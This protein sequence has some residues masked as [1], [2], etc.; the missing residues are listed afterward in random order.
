MDKMENLNAFRGGST[1]DTMQNLRPV[2][3]HIEMEQ[4]GLRESLSRD[5]NAHNML[6]QQTEY[7]NGG[8]SRSMQ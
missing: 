3:D 1:S 2:I 8:F 5:S 7:Q 6:I 4:L